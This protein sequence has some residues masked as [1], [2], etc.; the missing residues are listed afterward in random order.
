M[1]IDEA[2]E[3]FD[4]AT[5]AEEGTQ[6]VIP[7]DSLNDAN[8]A[9]TQ[10]YRQRNDYIAQ[11]GNLAKSIGIQRITHN[12]ELAERLG[13][14]YAIAIRVQAPRKPAT[15][16]RPGGD[17]EEFYPKQSIVVEKG[18][19]ENQQR[20]Y[21]LMLEDGYTKEDALAAAKGVDE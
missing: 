1:R 3:Y 20:M 2:K 9:R 13:Y 16:I 19:T 8:S 10:L 15:I 4:Q 18:M 14:K 7:C 17:T 11:V 6:I 5:T 12:A 21:D